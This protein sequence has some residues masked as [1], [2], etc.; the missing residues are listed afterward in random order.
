[1][2]LHLESF[3]GGRW[4]R[5]S[6]HGTALRN[7]VT[8]EELARA[9][10]EGIDRAAAL[11][12]A[13]EA[14]GPALR[15]LSLGERAELL[16]AVAELLTAKRE[17][18]G[19]IARLNSGNTATD[20]A[21]DIDGAIGTLKYYARLGGGLGDKRHLVEGEMLRLGK[22]PAFQAVH[23][24]V[25]RRG[26]AIHIN[27][28][29]FPAWGLW[30][31]A[32]CALLAGMPVLAKPATATC[33]LSVEMVRDAVE[34][35]VLPDGALSLLAGEAG[36][37]LDHVRGGDVVAFTGSHD[38]GQTIRAHPSVLAANVPVNI[39]ADSLNACLL[40]PEA[41]PGSAEFD[42]FVREVAREMTVKAGQKCTAIR[43][44]FAPAERLDAVADALVARLEKTTVG[45]PANPDVRMGP[46]VTAA[47]RDTVRQGLETLGR[48]AERLTGDPATFRPVDADVETGAFVPP[49]LLRSRDP[50]G[51]RAL[52]EV[53]VFGPVATLMP[54]GDAAEAAALVR[55]GAG[56]LVTSIFSADAGFVQDMTLELADAHGRLLV[57][58]E[59]VA[60]AQTGHGIV[61][62]MCAHG[63][64]GRAGNGLELG[65]LRGLGLYSQRTAV[66]GPTA[67]LDELVAAGA[68]LS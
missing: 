38:T 17:R 12:H 65:G 52:H 21:I 19:E 61:M 57:V 56:S 55:R 2:F 58:D 10:A 30:E 50:A 8:G 23:L 49:T 11:A 64:P 42:G 37:L 67:R 54:Y 28:F 25:P 24:L 51:A 1:M 40:G 60:K 36:D 14:G 46:L 32:A 45:D 68:P 62:P 48:E 35:G 4:Q 66:Q 6:G 18:Y 22:D 15:R 34:A 20:A 9:G 44:A 33:W 7:P 41:E 53:E 13:R 26:V 59:S 63:G 3:V 16:G 29:N 5:G 27:A 43:R 39:E 47:Q 31:K